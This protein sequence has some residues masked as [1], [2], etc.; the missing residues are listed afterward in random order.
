MAVTSDALL[1][2]QECTC[3]EDTENNSVT[4]TLVY[5]VTTD[6]PMDGPKTVLAAPGLPERGDS[7]VYGNDEDENARLIE[8]VASRPFDN[9]RQYWYVTCSYTDAASDDDESPKDK[10][11]KPVDDP[12]NARKIVNVQYSQLK[13]PAREAIWR[14]NSDGSVL[15]G[16]DKGERGPVVNTANIAFI[17]SPEKS[18]GITVVQHKVLYH[19]YLD[20]D[21]SLFYHSVN[22]NPIHIRSFDSTGETLSVKAGKYQA[23]LNDIN[24]QELERPNGVIWHW[25]TIEIWIERK[26]GWRRLFLSEGTESSAAPGQQNFADGSTIPDWTNTPNRPRV[27]PVQAHRD[28]NGTRLTNPIPLDKDGLALTAKDMKDATKRIKMTYSIQDELDW[29]PLDLD[30]P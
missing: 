23:F 30:R 24:V 4:Y 19:N 9:K 5:A 16:R 6:D 22:K 17:P 1:Q 14:E 26:F 29:T 12:I 3:T 21:F 7:Y 2:H 27:L 20:S 8:R 13:I 11:G 28:I 15:A 25:V 18:I 10:N